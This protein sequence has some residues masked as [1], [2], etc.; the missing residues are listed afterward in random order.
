MGR[1]NHRLGLGGALGREEGF[2]L[3]VSR[4]SED[5]VSSLVGN[6]A[7]VVGRGLTECDRYVANARSIQ[8]VEAQ[9]RLAGLSPRAI[10][11]GL[12]ACG[13]HT[14]STSAV[15][16]Y[17]SMNQLVALVLYFSHQ[18]G[19]EAFCVRHIDCI[20]D[21]HFGI[22]DSAV[23]SAP[24]MGSSM[25]ILCRYMLVVADIPLVTLDKEAAG[26][27]FRWTYP[28]LVQNNEILGARS[29]ALTIAR[30]RS[31]YGNDV[32]PQ[33]V[34][35]QMP[36]PNDTLPFR[37]AFR[38]P[39]EFGAEMNEILFD[40]AYMGRKNR[41]ADPYAH[42]IAIALANRILAERRLP[43]DLSIRT[44]EDVF[45][46]LSDDGPS[47]KETAKRLGMS[48]RSLQRRL[49]ELGTNFQKLADEVRATKAHLMLTDGDL[50]M[51][52]IAY[53]LGFSNQAN[54]TRA[55]KRWYG[56]APREVRQTM[57]QKA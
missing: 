27:W 26:V 15:D 14:V 31:L 13:L 43:D 41:I 29:V 36:L 57:G 49:E 12:E 25:E 51:G 10:E 2:V 7:P 34:S 44:R 56:K 28:P 3:P 48:T 11:A 39:V 4:Q 22:V 8:I 50:P 23:I 18:V 20:Q 21:G 32:T 53:Q 55:V 1:A 19:D 30:L 46:N 35:L 38:S 45:Q 54:F 5:L 33:R 16:T 52:E 6:R 37:D 47:I 24:D 42:E 9:A 40:R 17:I